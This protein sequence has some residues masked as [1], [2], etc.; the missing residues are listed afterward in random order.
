MQLQERKQMTKI[1]IVCVGK[2]KEKYLKDGI[3]EYSKRISR[4]AKLEIIELNDEKI[5]NDPSDAQCLAVLKAEGEKILKHLDGYIIPLCVEGVAL[6]SEELSEKLNQIALNGNST[7]TFII[8][9]SLG[10]DSRIKALADF[11]ISFSKMTFPHQLMRLILSEQL[12]RAFKI[13][14]NESYHK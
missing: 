5:P 2:L 14:A 10:L 3:E 11:K 8:G 6:S 9:G 1:K 12:Y 4:F 7:I 13:S